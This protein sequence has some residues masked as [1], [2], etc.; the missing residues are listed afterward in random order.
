MKINH[1]KLGEIEVKI[2]NGKVI[3][4]LEGQK[5]TA[6]ADKNY[7]TRQCALI[8]EKEF[9]VSASEDAKKGIAISEYEHAEIEKEIEKEKELKELLEADTVT[10]SSHYEGFVE[11]PVNMYS[12]AVVNAVVA[13]LTGREIKEDSGD[14]SYRTTYN[15]SGKELLKMLEEE[16]ANIEKATQAKKEKIQ[17]LKEKA[18]ETGEK[19]LLKSY[20][21]DCNDDNEEC[22]IDDVRVYI[23]PDG[24]QKIERNHTW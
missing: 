17:E 13:R 5:I 10:Y 8:S 4:D 16:E 7:S 14:Y 3:F 12:V 22:D 24:T 9:Y 18:K 15:V 23:M 1:E 20:T 6:K 2:K 11:A 21:E 19:Q